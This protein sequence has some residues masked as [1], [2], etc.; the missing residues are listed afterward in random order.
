MKKA[1]LRGDGVGA[2]LVE[3]WDEVGMR[4]IESPSLT[5]IAICVVVEYRKECGFGLGESS[6]A[7]HGDQRIVA[8]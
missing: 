4:K 8:K 1:M 3:I 6:C 2:L 7:Q 5:G